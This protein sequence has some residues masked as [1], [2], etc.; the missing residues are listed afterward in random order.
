MIFTPEA[1]LNLP[2]SADHLLSILHDCAICTKF[3]RVIQKTKKQKKK[4]KRWG[5]SFCPKQ[6]F[7]EVFK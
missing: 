5:R 2:L 6:F 7:L 4:K 1:Q 3:M